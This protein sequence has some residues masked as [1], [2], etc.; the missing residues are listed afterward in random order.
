MHGVAKIECQLENTGYYFSDIQFVGQLFACVRII[1]LSYHDTGM[2]DGLWT[3]FV[4]TIYR[5]W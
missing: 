3:I 2:R 5:T 1:N 4:D